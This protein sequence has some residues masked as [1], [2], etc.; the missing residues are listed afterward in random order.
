MYAPNSLE[1]VF[2]GGIAFCVIYVSSFVRNCSVLL[3]RLNM[4]N[5][6]HI[7]SLPSFKYIILSDKS[8]F[9]KDKNVYN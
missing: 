3:L 1:V 2:P 6:M 5:I 8:A 7:Y 9:L 4:A